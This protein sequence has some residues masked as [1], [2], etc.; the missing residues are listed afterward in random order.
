MAVLV[1][2]Y[3]GFSQ[4]PVAAAQLPW[5]SVLWPFYQFGGYAVQVFWLLSG[6]V[7]LTV[8]GQQPVTGREFFLR[9]FARLYPLHFVTLITMVV[10]D[11]M[12]R[13]LNGAPLLP[14]NDA[15]HFVLQ[16]FMASNWLEETVHSFNA[17]IWSVSMEVLAYGAFFAA[18]RAGWTTLPRVSLIAAIATA[19][20]LWTAR[21]TITC[22]ALFFIG[23]AVAHLPRVLGRWHAP[24]ASVGLAGA[25]V[26]AVLVGSSSLSRHVGIVLTY[27]VFP[28]VL[29]G[30]LVID[31]RAPPVPK[32]LR[33]IG[34]STYAV[35]L[36]HIPAQTAVLLAMKWASLP[37]P[38]AEPWLLVLYAGSVIWLAKVVYER[39]EVP[40]QRTI[41]AWRL[42][43]PT[44]RA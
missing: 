28:A 42:E 29:L 38:A 25:L 37:V 1:F 36:L 16:V 19:L 13:A 44:A 34:E 4:A 9:R 43:S 27:A 10:L 2:H 8:Y 30:V 23:T 11:Q 3:A 6:I 40:A 20:A 12:N 31:M 26:L 15:G 22:V 33:W 39:F 41:L 32:R 24:V 5:H 7:F 21:Y 17:P 18:L 14:A 35:Y